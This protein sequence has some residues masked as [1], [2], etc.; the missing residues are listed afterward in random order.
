MNSNLFCGDFP[1]VSQGD[2]VWQHGV[3]S[4]SEISQTS[5]HDKEIFISHMNSMPTFSILAPLHTQKCSVSTDSFQG[6]GNRNW[7]E[8]S[9]MSFYVKHPASERG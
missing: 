3:S 8:V 5:S 2:G 1:A 6:E 7:H 4:Q 9:R